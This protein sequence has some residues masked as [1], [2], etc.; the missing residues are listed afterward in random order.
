MEVY[1]LRH[2]VN[3]VQQPMFLV[4]ADISSKKLHWHCLQLDTTLMQRLDGASQQGTITVRV[5]TKQQLPGTEPQFLMA[6]RRSYNVLANRQLTR[7]STA[8]FAES[9]KYSGDTSRILASMQDKG[10]V[11]RLQRIVDLFHGGKLPEARQR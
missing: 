10:G 2:F 9:L 8:D 3:E 6:L 7:S 1:H 4:V 5:L 11:L